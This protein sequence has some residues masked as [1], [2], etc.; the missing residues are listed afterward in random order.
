MT[1]APDGTRARAK[2]A[3]WPI[4]LVIPACVLVAAV[5]VDLNAGSRMTSDAARAALLALVAGI[6]QIVVLLALAPWWAARLVDD[7]PFGALVAG[8]RVF[9]MTLATALPLA[10]LMVLETPAA[11][12]VVVKVQCVVLGTGLFAAGLAG[13]LGALF[14][15]IRGAAAFAS[16]VETAKAALP[17]A[18]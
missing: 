8:L 2:I 1:T 12:L 10:A 7:S 15:S 9:A 17:V 5:L 14:R 16:L 6:M 11:A 13:A 4:T 3:G 18:S